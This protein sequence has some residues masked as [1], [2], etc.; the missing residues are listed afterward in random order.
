MGGLLSIA[1]V[2]LG[3]VTA[4][5][6]T[7]WAGQPGKWIGRGARLRR[8][9]G[10][11]IPCRKG[12]KGSRGPLRDRTVRHRREADVVDAA[13]GGEL[14]AAI[15][16]RMEPAQLGTTGVDAIAFLENQPILPRKVLENQVS[17]TPADAILRN[18]VADAALRLEF[19]AGT[20]DCTV[21]QSVSS[22]ANRDLHRCKDDADR[23]SVVL[24]VCL[25]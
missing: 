21:A 24:G 3:G 9:I 4:W 23:V 14:G 8:A 2:L 16:S 12:T 5:H 1:A 6:P 19:H 7:M 25:A 20:S 22:M 13:R 10:G 18:N 15:A 17:R 11:A